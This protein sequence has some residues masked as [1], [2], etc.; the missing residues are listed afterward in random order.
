MVVQ[1]FVKLWYLLVDLFYRH[2]ATVL[3][4]ALHG[5]HLASGSRDKSIKGWSC[6][7]IF[8][9]LS[10]YR[11]IACHPAWKW[12]N[13]GLIKYKIAWNCPTYMLDFIVMQMSR[14]N[15]QKGFFALGKA[16]FTRRFCNFLPTQLPWET[17]NIKPCIKKVRLPISCDLF[18]AF[19]H[20][21]KHGYCLVLTW[22]RDY[23]AICQRK[24]FSQP[25]NLEWKLLT[26]KLS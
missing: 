10:C 17:W 21:M 1:Y 3:C 20:D 18:S 19:K 6:N 16:S 14:V 12:G 7:T 13:F 22:T 25:F 11:T 8:L 23:K 2:R 5:N 24:K 9:S 15:H 4:I 26:G